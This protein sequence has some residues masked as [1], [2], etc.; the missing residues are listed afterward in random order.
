MRLV[1]IRLRTTQPDASFTHGVRRLVTG[2]CLGSAVVV[3]AISLRAN[4]CVAYDVMLRWTVPATSNTSGYYVYTGPLSSTYNQHRDVG[5]RIAA[6]LNGV[7]YY[8]YQGIDQSI[9]AGSPVYVAVTAYNTARLESVYSNE[10]V[11]NLAAAVSP[12]VNA[13]PDQ[14]APVGTPLTLGSQGKDGLSYFWEQTAGPPASLSSRTSSSTVFNS[15][16]AGTFTFAV[17]AYNS[18]GGAAQDS[19]TVTLTNTS[20]PTPSA[21]VRTATPTP[22][23]GSGGSPTSTSVPAPTANKVASSVLV[24]GNR[25]RPTT[26]RSGCQVEWIVV[27]SGNTADRFGL[28]SQSQTCKDGDPTCDFKPETS[29]VCEFHLRVCL[30]NADPNLPAC[31]PGGIGAVDVRAPQPRAAFGADAYAMLTADAE[32]LQNAL[33]HLQAP[34]ESGGHSIYSPPLD[35]TEQG[36]CSGTF[37]V[38]AMVSNRSARPSVTLKT[39]SSD[40]ATLRRHI[41]VSQLRL[42]CS[43]AGE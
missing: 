21:P 11:F 1:G 19:V 28:P 8:F 16:S 17:T 30:N 29:G 15:G 18:Q 27:S 39:R 20:A 42:T 38:E 23:R 6:T 26:D 9:A 4:P 7:V 3:L 2:G 43:P 22:S 24:R 13:G 35:P 32:A 5:P 41:S 40:Y 33:T 34:G 12:Q 25:R 14:S 37:A 31:T 36:F 10:K